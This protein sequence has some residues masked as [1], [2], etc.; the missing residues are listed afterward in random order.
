VH[1]ELTHSQARDLFGPWVDDELAAPEAV[2]LKT[3]LDGCSDCRVGWEAYE[4]V[5]KT[6]RSLERQRAP[7]G[8]ASVIL[9]RVRRR[10]V[11]AH[12]SMVSQI[13]NR[14]P[15]EMVIPLLIAAAVIAMLFFAQR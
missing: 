5:V 8:L 11:G 7:E 3:H 15:V 4:R 10:R 14:L 13:Q 1:V 6:T 12:A 2:Q 9:R